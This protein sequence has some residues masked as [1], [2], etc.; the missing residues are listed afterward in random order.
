MPKSSQPTWDMLLHDEKQK[1]YFKKLMVFLDKEYA[2]EHTIYPP[3]ND[4]YNALKYTHFK[5]T[6]IVILGQDPYHGPNQ[7]HGIS[8]SLQKGQALT[9]SL[10]NI[11]KE[12]VHDTG[13]L[14]PTHGNLTPWA[15]QGVLMLN[16]CL[17]VRANTP[18]SHSKVGW[19]TFT[20]QIMATLNEHPKPIV[21]VFWGA[22]AAKKSALIDTNKH[23]ILTAP[24]PSPLS[25]YRG[26]FGSKPFSTANQFLIDN[27]RTPIDWQV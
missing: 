14:M 1:D 24:H 8:F 20:D 21:F 22:Y 12:L 16:S 4:L 10:R 23:K 9:P 18:L 6:K 3:K 13:I 27:G 7:A 19:Q 5:N 26:F 15:K 17:S 11:Y 2:G 25:A